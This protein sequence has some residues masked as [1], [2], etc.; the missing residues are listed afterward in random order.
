MT[1]DVTT[2]LKTL[3]TSAR[4]STLPINA[5]QGEAR[6]LSKE[7]LLLLQFAIRNHIGNDELNVLM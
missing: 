5:S 2:S 3:N 7:Y 4:S 6:Y 1:F